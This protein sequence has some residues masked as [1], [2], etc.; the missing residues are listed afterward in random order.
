M[1]TG[2]SLAAL[3]DTLVVETSPGRLA[4]PKHGFQLPNSSLALPP[5]LDPG[6]SPLAPAP[7]LPP[8]SPQT[9]TKDPL[10]SY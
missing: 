8:T 3:P 5:I 2:W 4:C 7:H 6:S 9:K 1:L 10:L